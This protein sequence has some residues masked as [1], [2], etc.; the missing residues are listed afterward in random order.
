MLNR[1][2]G[3]APAYMPCTLDCGWPW[4]ASF[5]LW[6]HRPTLGL[7]FEHLNCARRAFSVV[8]PSIWNLLPS[9]IRLLPKSYIRLCSTNSA[10]CLKLIFLFVVGLGASE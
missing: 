9:Q 7:P 8:D 10:N 1:L 5:Q 6:W 2:I 4:S 3:I